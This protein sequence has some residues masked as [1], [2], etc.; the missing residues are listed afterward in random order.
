M[1]LPKARKLGVE[2]PAECWCH[3]NVLPVAVK[4]I[5]MGCTESCGAPDCHPPPGECGQPECMEVSA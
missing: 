5:Q 2:L 1:T 3:C 4:K